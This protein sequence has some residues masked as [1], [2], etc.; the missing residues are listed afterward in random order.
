MAKDS[1]IIL[2]AGAASAVLYLALLIGS[3]GAIVLALLAPLPL[4]LV[5]LSR[6]AIPAL[7]ACAV[8][9]LVVAVTT[10][11][12]AATQFLL[13][14]GA[15]AAWIVYQALRSRQRAGG[16]AWAPP[17]YLMIQL[18]GFAALYFLAAALWY[19]GAEAG[20]QGEFARLIDAV[21]VRLA[22]ATGIV[23]DPALI[24]TW[25]T[26]MPA[27]IAV[28]WILVV[29]A[30]G[31][32]AQSVLRRFDRNLRPSLV[33]AD[34]ELPRGLAVAVGALLLLAFAPDPVGFLARTLAIIA[35]VPF[36]FLGLAL[37]H[38]IA[39][40]RPGQT[41]LLLAFYMLLVLLVWPVIMVA[42]FGMIEHLARLRRRFAGPARGSD[43]EDE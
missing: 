42:G 15:P 32:L 38:A 26:L 33:M 18:A 29:T 2:G 23:A 43:E 14:N 37:V 17:G 12:A 20:L 21:A 3:P 7:D 40:R 5:G 13:V 39:A 16:P 41:F 36:F 8:A 34:F 4:F 30:N 35:L 1:P 28:W 10:S 19:A 22:P 9:A 27:M 11:I 31:M 24:A 6:G 25:A